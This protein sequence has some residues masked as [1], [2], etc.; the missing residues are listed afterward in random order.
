M[1]PYRK[2]LELYDDNVS[3]R[4]IAQI[5]QHSRQK[6]T[7]MIKTADRKEVSLPLGGRNDG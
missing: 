1:F 2:I 7:E 5:V 4:S 6:V 3:L